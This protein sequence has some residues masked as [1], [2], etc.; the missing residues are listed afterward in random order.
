ML[1]CEL[2]SDV[3]CVLVSEVGVPFTNWS[4]GVFEAAYANLKFPR[5]RKDICESDIFASIFVN[6]RH[7]R[8]YIFESK[9]L[10]SKIHLDSP[11]KPTFVVLGHPLLREYCPIWVR[12][13]IKNSNVRH[14]SRKYMLFYFSFSEQALIPIVVKK[15]VCVP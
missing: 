5:T 15:A 8:N 3:P 7:G 2:P 1:A 6:N 13:M 12:N 4:N 9:S 10:L 11:I 14:F